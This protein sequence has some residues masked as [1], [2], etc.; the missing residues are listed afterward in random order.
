[1][2]NKRL[3]YIDI[4]KG[5]AIYFMVMAHILLAIKGSPDQTVANFIYTF[6]MPLFMFMSGY[7]FDLNRRNEMAG[8]NFLKLLKKGFITLIVPGTIW[9]LIGYAIITKISE[10][11]KIINKMLFGR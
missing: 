6:H 10:R 8:A 11:S 5:F 7:V 9:M 1:M 2:K 3:D 4:L